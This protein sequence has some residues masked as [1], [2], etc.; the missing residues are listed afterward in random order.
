MNT[1]TNKRNKTQSTRARRRRIFSVFAGALLAVLVDTNIFAAHPFALSRN[2]LPS[3]AP[4]LKVVTPAVVNVSGSTTRVRSSSPLLDDPFFRHFFGDSDLGRERKRTETSAGSGVIVDAERGYIVTNHHV[5]GEAQTLTVTLAD[6]REIRAERV[7]SD[8]ET[9]IALIRIKADK[10]HQ[11]TL[12]DSSQLEVGDFVVAIGNPFGVGQSVT[13]GIISGLGRSGLGIEG[14]E[15]F[16]QTDASINPGNSGGALINLNGELIG[17]NTAIIAPGGGNVGIGFSIPANMV[18]RL[19]AQLIEHGDVQ[20]GLLGVV[21]QDLSPSLAEAFNIQGRRGAVVTRVL[22]YSTAKKAGLQ[23]GDVIV[24]IDKQAVKNAA[25]LRNAI[26]LF[27]IGEKARIHY[28]RDGQSHIAAVTIQSEESTQSPTVRLAKRFTGAQFIDITLNTANGK[29]G[30][31]LVTHIEQQ[32]PAWQ[33]GLRESDMILQINKRVIHEISDM[34]EAIADAKGRL[35][36][37]VQ[38]DGQSIRIRVES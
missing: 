29:R 38:R 3:L 13:S 30:A 4:M 6:G 11:L 14:Y 18:K 10:L 8:P 32:S 1:G 2:G 31:V 35:S 20:R 34:R 28:L 7:G 26:G 33:M 16:I 12:G 17:I 5:L 15:D 27:R 36:M 25:D 9:D 19:V 23:E 22:D 21:T 37:E 24:Q